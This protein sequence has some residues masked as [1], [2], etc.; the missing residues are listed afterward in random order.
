MIADPPKKDEVSKKANKS[1]DPYALES[2]PAEKWI[3]TGDAILQINDKEKTYQRIEI[4]ESA[5]GSNI[6]HTP[7]PF[8]FGMT[9]VEA[10]TRFKL[11]LKANTK[12]SAKILVIPLMEKDKQN[13]K[14]ALVTLSKK[15]YLPMEVRMLGEEST[16]VAYTFED[17]KMNDK[18]LL[19]EIFNKDPYHPSLKGYRLVIPNDDP[20]DIQPA[21]MI[22]GGREPK[23]SNNDTPLTIPPRR[24]SQPTTN[25]QKTSSMNK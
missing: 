21:R 8:L 16:E 5:R 20:A 11:S 25:G 13:Y 18:R 14:K 23:K 12:D 6:V 10:K 22:N 17:V 15:T 3:C 9:A 1:G 24:N 4:P 2:G 7:L 19:P